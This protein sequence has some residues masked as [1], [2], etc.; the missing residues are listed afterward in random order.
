MPQGGWVKYDAKSKCRK[1]DATM[2]VV[3]K[4]GHPHSHLWE[5]QWGEM[6]LITCPNLCQSW[7]DYEGKW[8]EIDTSWGTVETGF[9][10]WNKDYYEFYISQEPGARTHPAGT[11]VRPEEIKSIRVV[12]RP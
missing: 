9:A 8:V 1:C 11:F 6:I 4:E 2:M 12:E 7:D 3:P 10:L 5:N